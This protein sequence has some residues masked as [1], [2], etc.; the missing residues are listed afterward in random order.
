[1]LNIFVL[2]IHYLP[3]YSVSQSK[4]GVSISLVFSFC[5]FRRK[6]TGKQMKEFVRV[7]N[8]LLRLLCVIVT[9][10]HGHTYKALVVLAFK[11]KNRLELF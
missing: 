7:V 9:S 2:E 4:N 6:N 5:C 10:T 1:M 8:V 11:W 3:F